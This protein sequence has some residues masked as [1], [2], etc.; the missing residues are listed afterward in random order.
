MIITKLDVLTY[1]GEIDGGVCDGTI[2]RGW[3]EKSVLRH[4]RRAVKWELRSLEYGSNGSKE[5][6]LNE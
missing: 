2:V 5:F 4:A 1:E 3:S 6:D